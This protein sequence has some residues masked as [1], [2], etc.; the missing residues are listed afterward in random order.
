MECYLALIRGVNVGGVVLKMETLRE[1]LST[2]GYA[3]VRTYIQSGN[4]LFDTEKTDAGAIELEIGQLLLQETGLD[5]E[6]FVWSRAELEMIARRHPFER[7]G[8]L[9]Y[10]FVTLLRRIPGREDV[11]ALLA[12]ASEAE[13]FAL[14]GRTVYSIYREGYG[15]SRFSNNYLEKKLRM[16]ATTRNWNSIQKLREMMDSPA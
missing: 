1:L 7:E 8:E 13:S 10:L 4:V 12:E 9:R 3:S 11:E 5:L 14:E 16:P 15:K 2:A 6:I